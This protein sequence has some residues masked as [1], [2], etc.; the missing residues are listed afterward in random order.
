MP[1]YCRYFVSLC[2]PSLIPLVFLYLYF[3]PVS[4]TASFPLYLLLL[5]LPPLSLLFLCLLFFLLSFSFFLLLS[6]SLYLHR[7]PCFTPP[8]QLEIPTVIEPSAVGGAMDLFESVEGG[9][10][11]TETGA[12]RPPVPFGPRLTSVTVPPNPLRR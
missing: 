3:F 12:M 6:P 7:S 4:S 10:C 5:F 8:P 11:P 1:L 9:A 2:L